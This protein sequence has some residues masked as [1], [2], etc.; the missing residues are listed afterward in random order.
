MFVSFTL[1]LS[2]LV[3]VSLAGGEVLAEEPIDLLR[4]SDG[5]SVTSAS[6]WSAQ[7]SE[8]LRLAGD[9]I[10]GSRP[11]PPD[12]TI[13]KVLSTRSILKGT[14]VETLLILNIRRGRQNVAVRVG[15]IRPVTTN[16]C[17]VVIKN[18]R[19]LFD[20]SAMP[21]GRKRDQY[22]RERRDETF[23]QVCESAIK[24]GYAICKFVREDLAADAPNSR[25]T[26]V[27]AMYSEHSWGAL[28]AWAW[29]YTP[30]IDYLIKSQN[31]DPRR[32][33][34]TGHS[35]GG[36]T[37][38]AAAIFDERIAISAPS[39]SGSGGTGSMEYFTPGGRRQTC[40]EIFKNHSHWF[41]P[42]L[43]ELGLS[44]PL[45]VD[46]HVLRALVAPR[47]IINTQGIDD[48]L[49]NP[50]GTKM[51]FDASEPVFALLGAGGQTATHW[52]SGGHG[53]NF[54]D[55]TAVL[56]YADAYFAGSPLPKRFNNWPRSAYKE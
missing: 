24:R 15:V 45:Q 20:L 13:A 23:E 17:A 19:W 53:Q 16:A 51:M 8:L 30:V 52:R 54:D 7:R 22:T 5:S 27:L 9:Y 48:T 1:V 28:A 35:R 25:E 34:A 38:L 37:A 47:G 46:G 6:E 33:I 43:K 12:Q 56:D 36:K 49:A 55:W 29:G 4:R 42:R 3:A 50:V 39:A 31:I 32:I 18:D 14:A 40:E 2:L 21:R 10:Y 44:K 11:A 26:G 41:S